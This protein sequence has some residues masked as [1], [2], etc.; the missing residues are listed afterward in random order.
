MLIIFAKTFVCFVLLVAVSS[1]M[2]CRGGATNNDPPANGADKVWQ[3]I[4]QDQATRR[5]DLCL[6]NGDTSYARGWPWTW[7]VFHAQTSPFLKRIPAMVSF[8]N[9]EFDFGLNPFPAGRG[10]DSGGEA[11]IASARRF[12]MPEPVN[13]AAA[14]IITRASLGA[15]TIFTLSSEHDPAAQASVLEELLPRVNRSVTPW[16]KQPRFFT[17]QPCLQ[18]RIFCRTHR[19]RCSS[20]GPCFRQVNWTSWT[21]CYKRLTTRCF[22]RT[23]WTL[24]FVGICIITNAC[25]RSART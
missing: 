4:L 2:S 5:D 13:D 1:F 10:G 23:R 18:I 11:G 17:W 14:Q 19:W 15:L 6:F 21:C 7:E 16:V 9:H 3:A 20:T 22:S 12:S 24:C 25:A 8:G